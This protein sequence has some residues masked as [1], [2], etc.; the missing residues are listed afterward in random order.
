MLK[1]CA[2]TG[3]RPTRFNFTYN[4]T[5]TGCKRLKRRLREQFMLLYEQGCR[6][7]WVGGALGVDMWAGEI[8]L[9]LK[10]QPE[11]SDIQLHITLP[12]EGHDTAWEERSHRRMSSLIK[13]STET[14]IVGQKETLPALNYRRR[15]EYMVD[16]AELLLAVY[17]NNRTIRSGTGMTVR[18]AEKKGLSI[19]LIHPD[20]GEISYQAE[21]T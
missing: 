8:L 5:H 19:T 18:L 17:D 20:T 13:H 11:Y 2:I 16:R 7:F 12:F 15:N 6:Q 9:R 21:K 10:K 4:E 1:V 14:V 3:H